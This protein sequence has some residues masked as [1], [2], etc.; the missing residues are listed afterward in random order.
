LFQLK[1]QARGYVW[2][3]QAEVER[4]EMV[5]Q[6]HHDPVAYRPAQLNPQE[7]QQYEQFMACLRFE[8]LSVS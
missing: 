4:Y 2:T 3:S 8:T 1:L 5:A 7:A 6:P